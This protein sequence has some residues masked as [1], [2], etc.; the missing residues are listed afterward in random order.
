[1]RV[2]AGAAKGRTLRVPKVAGLRPTSDRARESL[3][4]VLAAGVEG[5]RVID[6]F[7]GSGALGIEA[8]SR[9]A[10]DATFVEGNRRAAEVL[11]ENVEKCGFGDRAAILVCDWRSGLRQL[12]RTL[13]DGRVGATPFD[14]ALFDPPYDWDRSCLCLTA[15]SAESLLAGDGLA[16]IEH[17]SSTEVKMPAGWSLLRVLKV[18]DSSFSLC[19]QMP[20][21]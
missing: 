10:L 6:A 8:L 1:M 13:V 18:G 19:T 9:G 5:A 16:V 14:L 12:G 4:N 15:L 17:R 20:A 7:A 11:A 2:I 3:F 21:G